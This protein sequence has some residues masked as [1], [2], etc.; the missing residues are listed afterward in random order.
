VSEREREGE[1]ERIKAPLILQRFCLATN[2]HAVFFIII[3]DFQF[4]LLA[5]AA[6]CWQPHKEFMTLS[7]KKK[8]KKKKRNNKHVNGIIFNASP[9]LTII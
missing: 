5:A 6:C 4:K 8:K 9:E 3:I 1:S 2:A 7:K